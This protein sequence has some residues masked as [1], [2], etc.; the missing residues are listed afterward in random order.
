MKEEELKNQNTFFKYGE[1]VWYDHQF[2]FQITFTKGMAVLSHHCE[3]K[4][5]TWFIK[6]LK[7][8]ED[9]KKVYEA[10]NDTEFK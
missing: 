6:Y 7:N 10:I 9:L 3:V 1:N 5:D 2:D 8:L 4:G